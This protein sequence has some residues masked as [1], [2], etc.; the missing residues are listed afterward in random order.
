MPLKVWWDARRVLCEDRWSRRAR[1][2]DLDEMR[3]RFV[4]L[5]VDGNNNTVSLVFSARRSS[6]CFYRI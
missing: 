3:G 5:I 4:I 2:R 6:S 1:V